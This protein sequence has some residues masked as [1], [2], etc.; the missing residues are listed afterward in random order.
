MGTQKREAAATLETL[1]SAVKERH[2]LGNGVIMV[3]NMM[4]SAGLSQALRYMGLHPEVLTANGVWRPGSMDQRSIYRHLWHED[5]FAT[6]A[7][8][9]MVDLAVLR[10]FGLGLTDSFLPSINY[11]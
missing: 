2:A 3:L 11:S 7:L 8:S 6:T 10:L 9:Q 4:M 1:L 5:R